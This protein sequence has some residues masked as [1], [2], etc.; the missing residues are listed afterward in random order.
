MS[1]KFEVW[2]VPCL[3]LDHKKYE[4]RLLMTELEKTTLQNVGVLPQDVWKVIGM[5][6][7]ADAKV[8]QL[9]KELYVTSGKQLQ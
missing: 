6:A 1:A 8:G 4:L 3:G 5:Q 2:T 7:I 9:E